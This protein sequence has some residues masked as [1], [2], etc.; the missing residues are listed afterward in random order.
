MESEGK[1]ETPGQSH[2]DVE[3]ASSSEKPTEEAA[4]SSSDAKA[5]DAAQVPS[6]PALSHGSRKFFRVKIVGPGS[7]DVVEH[8]IESGV[9]GVEV[10][11]LVS[12]SADL[13]TRPRVGL[14]ID[15]VSQSTL[16]DITLS[17]KPNETTTIE[18]RPE[19][20][21]YL[22]VVNH[23]RQCVEIMLPDVSHNAIRGAGILKSVL[24]LPVGVTLEDHAL[25][26]IITGKD[27]LG[28]RPDGDLLQ[29]PMF[30]N[31][32]DQWTPNLT[33]LEDIYKKYDVPSSVQDLS[34]SK[35]NPPTMRAKMQGDL[36]YLRVVTLEK[37]ILHITASS[38]GFFLSRSSDDK[39]DPQPASEPFSCHS[40]NG[41]LRKISPQFKSHFEAACRT[42]PSMLMNRHWMPLSVPP[43]AASEVEN[44]HQN[45]WSA[46]EFKQCGA[47]EARAATNWEIT[48]LC[49]KAF[50]QYHDDPGNSDMLFYGLYMQFLSL[51]VE[52]SQL[53][54]EGSVNEVCPLSGLWGNIVFTSVETDC[55]TFELEGG[56]AAAFASARLEVRGQELV[57]NVL[58]KNRTEKKVLPMAPQVCIDYRGH[59]LVAQTLIP[60]LLDQD[61]GDDFHKFV[62]RGFTGTKETQALAWS[63]EAFESLSKIQ[64]DMLSKPHKLFDQDGEV[65]EYNTSSFVKSMAGSDGRKYFFE[66]TRSCPVDANFVDI[67]EGDDEEK[68]KKVPKM[69]HKLFFLR[70]ELVSDFITCR[71]WAFLKVAYNL[72]DEEY[73]NSKKAADSE[74]A[75]AAAT[76]STNSVQTQG[77][78]SQADDTTDSS[79]RTSDSGI[80]EG[81]NGAQVSDN[82]RSLVQEL[83]S[84]VSREASDLLSRGSRAA[85]MQTMD[86]KIFSA[87]AAAMANNTPYRHASAAAA[88]AAASANSADGEQDEQ[89][90]TAEEFAQKIISKAARLVGSYDEETYRIGFNLD[91][92]NPYAKHADEKES[93]MADRQMVEAA[94]LFL[95][96]TVLL[97]L[98]IDVTQLVFSAVDSV[99]L[100]DCMHKRGVNM[101]YLGNLAS[102]A[103]ERPELWYIKKLCISDI[104]M[105]SLKHIARSYLRRI[106][107]PSFPFAMSHFL[108]CFLSNASNIKAPKAPAVFAHAATNQTRKNKKKKGGKHSNSSNSHS[109]QNSSAAAAAATTGSSTADCDADDYN[110]QDI[111]PQKLWTQI[112]DEAQSYYRFTLDCSSSSSACSKYGIQPLSLLRGF[113]MM[114]GV[115]IQSRNYNFNSP[116]EATF[117]PGDIINSHPILK[118]PWFEPAG[119]EEKWALLHDIVDPSI[120]KQILV[121]IIQI[122]NRTIGLVHPQLARANSSLA[123]AMYEDGD[124]ATAVFHQEE[125]VRIFEVACGIDNPLT[126]DAYTVL[127]RYLFACNQ[128]SMAL[129]MAHHAR[130]LL[131]LIFGPD[132][133]METALDRDIGEYLLERNPEL[134]LKFLLR[135]C[136]LYE[137]YE[138]SSRVNDLNHA[139][140]QHR[141]AQCYLL[142]G[143][144]RSSLQAERLVYNAY[145]AGLGEKHPATQHCAALL[146]S[147]TFKAVKAEKVLQTAIQARQVGASEEED[148]R[149]LLDLFATLSQQQAAGDDLSSSMDAGEI[150][151]RIQASVEAA[152]KRAPTSKAASSTTDEG[153]TLVNGDASSSRGPQSPAAPNATATAAATASSKSKNKKKNK[154]GKSGK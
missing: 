92:G 82:V 50:E 148:R 43:W 123:S 45:I 16:A 91:I 70:P 53:M 85:N 59:R 55:D 25:Q 139:R 135:S 18:V 51:V 66:F 69:P 31:P 3:V 130:S 61:F 44:H 72:F 56:E 150:E 39:F 146:K 40:L 87:M 74:A 32:L 101:R 79:S 29:S 38:S 33:M 20:Y 147:I 115:Q 17:F 143:D 10:L 114:M 86:D 6:E 125:A 48:A 154:K 63:Q 94:S 13:V 107:N 24:R 122:Y 62:L 2:P 109:H 90:K 35:W 120:R 97:K 145:K 126:I 1:D 57:W 78:A 106:P 102:C 30:T 108:N 41:C 119:V 26:G 95:V 112:V 77:E 103:A 9:R 116:Y 140:V 138:G 47:L 89:T 23:V 65:H 42:I 54:V 149:E 81:S 14:Y 132:H 19:P 88:T 152:K 71:R 37:T 142:L 136:H 15:G 117:T 105:R 99:S 127:G 93:L 7:N 36:L 60:G 12:N 124:Y 46:F 111:T 73:G 133:P 118:F 137:K 113:C 8:E 80:S 83:N 76:A 98:V 34:L 134:A 58:R 104:I 22:D 5:S 110:W 131:L 144:Y 21:S 49:Q 64:D 84:G 96:N 75:A 27:M 153:P 11:E 129:Q 68:S 28:T 67:H 100:R 52:G 121:E 128:V 4:S 151:R 141:V